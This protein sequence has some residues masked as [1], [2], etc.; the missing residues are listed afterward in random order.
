[1]GHGGY[2][3]E[4]RSC[5]STS[6]GYHTKSVNEI[7][8]QQKERKI[9]DSMSPRNV[10]KRECC[11]SQDH[12][13]TVPIILSLDVTGSMGG[14]P[15]DLVK[16]GLPTLMGRLIQNGVPDASLLFLAAGD[17][18]CDR[19]PF[20]VGQFEASDELLDQ[21]LT[22]T[23]IEGGGGGN[24]GESYSLAWYFGANH[25]S[26]DSFTKR[27]KKGFLFTVGDEPCLDDIPLSKLKEIMGDTVNGQV[28]TAKELLKAA[29]KMYN[30]YHLHIM[31]GSAGRDSLGYWKELLGKN[32]IVVDNYKD[33]PK[34]ISDIIIKNT[35]KSEVAQKEPV[36]DKQKPQK[37]EVVEETTL[38]EEEIL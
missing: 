11:D 5:R 31:Q 38:Q 2:D 18:Y 34:V 28:T 15:H 16:D 19:Y 20:Q 14:I 29:Q 4:A 21:W 33:L 30:V 35:D 1:M 32:C 9:H 12:P 7:F 13:N 23:Y 6:L 37:T 10:N 3:S 26:L 27:N 24:E 8:T 22:R 17:V 36:A 25:T